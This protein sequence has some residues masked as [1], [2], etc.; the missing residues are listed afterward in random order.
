MVDQ[1]TL[2]AV[3]TDQLAQKAVSLYQSP[4]GCGKSTLAVPLVDRINQLLNSA[5]TDAPNA[6]PA[7]RGAAFTFDVHA[8]SRFVNALV[9]EAGG[10]EVPFFEFDHAEKDPVPATHPIHPSNRIVVIEGLYCL[11]DEDVWRD[12][13][14]KMDIRIWVEVDRGEV[15]QR[16]IERN[17][18]AG[19]APTRDLLVKRARPKSS[20]ATVDG[21]TVDAS[22]MRN[23]EEIRAKRVAPTDIVF[24]C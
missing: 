6:R 17:F 14:A 22:D 4:P 5:P 19:L 10:G 8:Y 2:S 12:T 7:V 18:A 11:L 21:L 16:L 15:R 1:R 9:D 24:S 3:E 20:M 23:G 13:A